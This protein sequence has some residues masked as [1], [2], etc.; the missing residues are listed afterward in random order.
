M[1]PPE[2]V[3]GDRNAVFVTW[4]GPRSTYLRALFLP[5]LAAL[6][7]HGYRFHVLQFTWADLSERSETGQ[8]CREYGIPYRSVTIWRRPI[9]AG[10]LLTALWGRTHVRRA[11]R[12]WRIDLLM[13]RSTLPALAAIG[14]RAPNGR[15]LPVLLDADGLPHDERVD[16]HGASP[17]ALSQRILR[18]IEA[19]AV[20]AAEA[21]TVRTSTAARILTERA[22]TDKPFF[23]VANGRDPAVFRP[24][25][26]RERV[27]SRSQLGLSG[28][29]PLLVYCGSSLH[30]KYR[31]EAMLRFFG[32]VRARM[33]DARLLLLLP[34]LFEAR[35]MLAGQPDLASAC[36]L[37]SATPEEVPAWLSAADL[38]LSL[39]HASF[40]MQAASPIK[41]GEYLLCG[42]PVL[43]SAGVG[44]NAESGSDLGCWLER[45]DDPSLAAAADWFVDTV[46]PDREGF[47]ERCRSAG[48]A[49][50]SIDVAVAGYERALRRAACARSTIDRG[51]IASE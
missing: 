38:G 1:A 29:Q 4:D 42:V 43:G 25:D 23:V 50:H 28:D 9:A 2:T 11:V 19:W 27:E 33:P 30:G 14:V 17:S 39:I 24:Q 31:G 45:V 13:P 40:S 37:R 21:V 20:R 32:H 41:I 5:I 7:K 16:F 6:R 35:A 8:A 15:N 48:L 10:S 49:D 46:L 34:D 47:R 36:L 22:G 12:D 3:S 26:G 51:M 44:E 18:K